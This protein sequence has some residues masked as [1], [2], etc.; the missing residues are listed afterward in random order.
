MC[1]EENCK[2]LKDN[3]KHSRQE[4]CIF[5]ERWQIFF[6]W[7]VKQKII[8]GKSKSGGAAASWPQAPLILNHCQT[9]AHK[10]DWCFRQLHF[11]IH[12]KIRIIQNWNKIN[13]GLHY[14]HVLNEAKAVRSSNFV[15]NKNK[16]SNKRNFNGNCFVD[17]FTFIR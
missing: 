15:R 14:A 4:R 16:R 7:I 17:F 3:I 8:I 1:L 2:I 5:W 9:Y 13:I 12:S 11:L 10:I 6:W